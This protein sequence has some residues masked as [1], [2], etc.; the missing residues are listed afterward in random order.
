MRAET[1][2]RAGGANCIV[3][4]RPEGDE[5]P[6]H[7]VYLEVVKNEKLVFTDACAADWQPSDKPFMTAIVTFEDEGGKTHYAARARHWTPEDHVA[8]VK[9]GFHEGW[10]RATDQLE[11]LVA[12][13]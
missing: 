8:H 4:R 12:R 2:V 9:M 10:G 5:F 3:M 7:G 6:N 11:A 1:D 13:L